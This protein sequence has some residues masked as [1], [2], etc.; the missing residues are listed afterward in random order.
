[1]QGSPWPGP[2]RR[3]STSPCTARWS[4]WTIL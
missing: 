4:P 3:R 1:M 2:S